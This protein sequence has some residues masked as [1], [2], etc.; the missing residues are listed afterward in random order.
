M[1]VS[2]LKTM[3]EEELQS[4]EKELKKELFN[5]KFQLHTGRLENSA[6]L[7]AIR[8]DVARVKTLLQEKKG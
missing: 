7:S 1:K 3:N 5:L 4:K 6:K 8:K 2:D